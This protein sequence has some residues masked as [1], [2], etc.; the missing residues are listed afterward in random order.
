[1]T[2]ADQLINEGLV[3]GR[4]EGLREGIEK[5]IEKGREEGALR[6]LIG[7]VQMLQRLLGRVA[8][9]SSALA[10][11]SREQLEAT[12]TRLERDLNERLK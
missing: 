8:D 1:M 3:K 9:P 2:L 6:A 4:E 5:G 11:S 12:I 7:Q 10:G